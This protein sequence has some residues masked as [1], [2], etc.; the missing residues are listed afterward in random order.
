MM[1]VKE[2]GLGLFYPVLLEGKEA[3]AKV[4]SIL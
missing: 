3:R 4:E 1:P 2:P